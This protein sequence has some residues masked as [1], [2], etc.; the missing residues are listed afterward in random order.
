M[1][2]AAKWKVLLVEDDRDQCEAM[3]D[4]LRAEGFDV[5]TASSGKE[6]IKQLHEGVAVVIT[7]LQMP[8]LSGLDVLR[9]AKD[10]AP[11]AAVILVTGHGTIQ[12]ARDA[13]K[14]GAFDYLVK[15]SFKP[16]DL[17]NLVRQAVRD[18]EI[19]A[20]IADLHAK[21]HE[22][23]SFE[24]LVG[25]S[26]AMR[27]VFERIKLAADA[28]STVLI[29]GETGTGKEMVAR[30]LHYTSARRNKPFLPINCA[31]IPESLIESELFGHE[32]GS[33]TGATA[34][35][36]GLFEAADS[37]TLFVDEIGEMN[38]G[39]QSKVL[40]AIE[41]RRIM[42][43]GSSKEIEVDVRLIAATNRDL[44]EEVKNKNFRE[45]LYY[46]LKVVEIHLPLLRERVEDIPILARYFLDQI[47]RENQKPAREITDEAMDVLLSYSW[48]GNVRELRNTLEGIVVL[49]A[50]EKIDVNDLPE[51][52]RRD[53]SA[54]TV[55]RAGV[56]LA[57]IEKEAI[58][59]TLEQT[60]G[61]RAEA[62]RILDMSVSALQRK[63]KQHELPF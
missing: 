28:K 32:K 39:L 58:R 55:V 20:K 61:R 7:D 9:L 19:T 21:V 5:L 48:P 34:R 31:A 57:E 33:F 38:Q 52:I 41:S 4:W 30:A 18:R 29:T 2:E 12:S 1:A 17:T 15:K 16:R 14:L 43:V 46:R 53:A 35:K 26:D 36:A 13:L 63:I 8:G 22:D 3:G 44:W 24:N 59:K 50:N 37:G 54:R 49:S 60:E 27:A 10:Q 23:S 47:V 45:D 40:R 56:T 6:A 11:H 62:A 25:R 51:H 42:P